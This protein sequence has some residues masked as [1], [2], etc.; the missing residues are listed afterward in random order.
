MVNAAQP[1]K[2]T[3]VS[4]TFKNLPKIFFYIFNQSHA[5]DG[6]DSSSLVEHLENAKPEEV[7]I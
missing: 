7:E 6:D 1:E 2:I 3:S 5:K 4:E